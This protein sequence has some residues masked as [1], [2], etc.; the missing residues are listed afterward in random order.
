MGRVTA[1]AMANRFIRIRRQIMSESRALKRIPAIPCKSESLRRLTDRD[2][3]DVLNCLET[4]QEWTQTE[5]ALT[6]ACRIADGKTPGVNPGDRRVLW[7]L[8][9]GFGATAVLE[10]GTNVGASTLHI[11]AALQ[12]RA[13]RDSSVSP[14]LVTV[15][16]QDVNYAVSGDWKKYG[17]MASPRD[18]IQ[19]IGCGDLVSFVTEGSLTYLD[20]CKDEFDF[21]FLDGDHSAPAVYQE[22]PRALNVLKKNGLILMHDYFPKNRP[23]W[24]NGVIVPGPCLAVARLRKEGTPIRAVPL[25]DL[26][27]PTKL[28]SRKT[29]L[30]LLTR[31]H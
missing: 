31:D 15:D 13:R 23:L 12:S 16:I 9:K 3:S 20:R 29:S 11:V 17:L 7:Y 2:L 28:G 30:A 18:M 5:A 24:T 1:S 8:I 21:I 27:W 22:I 19:A 6:Q 26:P 4:L 10:V 25:G 14:H